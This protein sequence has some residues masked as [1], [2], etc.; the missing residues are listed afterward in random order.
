MLG[1]LAQYLD[2]A[3]ALAEQVRSALVYPIVLL[4]MAGLSIV[5]L[6]TVVVPQFTPLFES[7]GAELPLL[8]R[9]VIAT[10]DAAQR[11]WWLLLIALA[12]LRLAG[13]PPVPAGREPR[14]DRPLAADACRCSAGCWPRSTRR[15]SPARW[16]RCSPTACRS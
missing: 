8:T 15:A 1:R 13:A 6:L 9:V 4:V 11:Y 12:A 14:P 7:A 3:E 2:Q 16:A 5:V 10:G